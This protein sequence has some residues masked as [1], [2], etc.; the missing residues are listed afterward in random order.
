MSQPSGQNATAA[1]QASASGQAPQSPRNGMEHAALAAPLNP[2]AVG[3]TGRTGIGR[4]LSSRLA[5]VAFL[6]LL[7]GGF[8]IYRIATS[9]DVSVAALKVSDCFDAP[10]SSTNIQ[11]VQPIPCTQ[12]HDSQVFAEVKIIE[13]TFPGATELESEAQ[14]DC[15]D[16]TR[17]SAISSQAPAGVGVI[18]LF[19][20][21][22][23]TFAGQDY[24]VCALQYP[25]QTLTQ[26]YVD[27]SA[28]GS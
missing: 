1:G 5:L 18:D 13:S 4:L 3:K 21:D 25:S 23:T 20:Q 14:A 19:P 11:G 27:P 28:S 8:A 10:S 26:S 2:V 6:V 22:A 17:Q 16:T 12:S 15:S 7:L 9:H 24:V